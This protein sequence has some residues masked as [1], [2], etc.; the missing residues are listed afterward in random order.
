MTKAKQIEALKAEL[1]LVYSLFIEVSEY[2]D[3]DCLYIV[4][5]CR[6]GCGQTWHFESEEEAKVGIVDMA[7]KLAIGIEVFDF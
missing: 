3:K 2:S 6:G 1:D 7:K 4:N 5:V